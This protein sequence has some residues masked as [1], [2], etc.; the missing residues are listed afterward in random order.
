MTDRAHPQA[1]QAAVEGI[2]VTVVIALLLA[3]LAAWMVTTT[4]PPGHA[5]D[6][7][8]RVAEP[9]AG[10]YDARLWERPS[11]PSLPSLLGLPARRRGDGPI[12][13]VLRRVGSGAVTGVVVGVQARNQFIGGFSERLRERAAALIRDPLGDGADLPDADLLTPGG[14]GLVVAQRAGA[15][16]D[17]AQFLRTLPPRTAILR[18]SR[19]AGRVSADT[20]VQAAQAAL[21]RR[22]MRGRSSPPTT[23]PGERTPPRAP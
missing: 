12:G 17:Y 19:D 22:L 9:L 21:R 6:V 7:I 11:L 14:I 13:R 3:A 5:P 18:A 15:L 8:G 23:P 1:G 20:A 2:G 4:H 16:W 10:P